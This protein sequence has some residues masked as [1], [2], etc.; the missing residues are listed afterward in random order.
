MSDNATVAGFDVANGVAIL[1]NLY[2]TKSGSYMLLVTVKTVNTND[3]NFQCYTKGILVTPPNTYMPMTGCNQEQ[4]VKFTLKGVFSALSTVQVEILKAQIY[5]CF[6]L[7]HNLVI[8]CPMNAYSG[9]V[10]VTTQL[11]DSNSVSSVNSMSSGTSSGFTSEEGYP[12]TS[13]SVQGST[14]YSSDGSSSSSDSNSK[15]KESTVSLEL[16]D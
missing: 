12:L 4:N 6:I 11:S 10:V 16:L 3:Y 2:V 1:N 8:T 5:N 13:V 14:V 9:S 7:P 15:S